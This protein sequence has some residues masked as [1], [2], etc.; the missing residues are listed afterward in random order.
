MRTSL[1]DKATNVEMVN[2]QLNYILEFI[3][4][5]YSSVSD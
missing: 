2:M 1:E 3:K 5:T 4:T